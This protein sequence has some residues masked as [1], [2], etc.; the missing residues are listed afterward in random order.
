[1]QGSNASL[2]DRPVRTTV[3]GHHSPC[4]I[5]VVLDDGDGKNRFPAPFG[6]CNVPLRAVSH[7]VQCLVARIARCT[8]RLAARFGPPH[9]LHASRRYKRRRA[10]CIGSLHVSTRSMRS[11]P[12][13]AVPLPALARHGHQL[14]TCIASLRTN[15]RSQQSTKSSSSAQSGLAP[16]YSRRQSPPR[17]LRIPGAGWS[18]QASKWSRSCFR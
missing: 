9:V 8:I 15:R 5:R 7:R 6:R 13:R 1:M 14:V 4:I 2:R 12:P 17:T 18:W 16:G 3:S 11:S 10:A